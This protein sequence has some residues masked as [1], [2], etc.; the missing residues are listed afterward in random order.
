MQPYLRDGSSCSIL[1][2]AK[3]SGANFGAKMRNPAAPLMAPV[4]KTDGGRPFLY[5]LVPK[6]PVCQYLKKCLRPLEF[7]LVP[8]RTDAFGSKLGSRPIFAVFGANCEGCRPAAFQRKQ[9]DVIS[10]WCSQAKVVE[11]VLW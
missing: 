10:E 4:L 2:Y 6:R 1:P 11:R 3:S 7:R 9:R 8:K 5:R